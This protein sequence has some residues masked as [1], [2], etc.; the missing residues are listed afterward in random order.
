MLYFKHDS[1][2]PFY[3]SPFGAAP[4]GT[5]VTFRV[6][7]VD[8][9]N[10]QL[11]TYFRGVDHYYPMVQSP[12]DTQVYE[13]TLKLPG[14]TGL[15]WYDFHFDAFNAH[16]VYGTQ[17]D[18]IGGEGQV[19]LF[20]SNSYQ[21]TIYD[22]KRKVPDWYKEGLMYQIFPD[23]FAHGT[24]EGF[25]PH[26]PPHT[27]LHTNWTDSPH[28]FR[29]RADGSID[30]WDF[31]GGNLPGIVDKLDYLKDMGVS[32]LYLNPI[33]EAMSN[34][35]YDTADYMKIAGEFG[36]TEIF[37]TLCREAGKRGIRVILDGVFNHTGDDSRYFNRYG[38]FDDVGAYQSTESPYYHWYNFRHYPDDYDS[39]WGVRSMPSMNKDDHDYQHFIYAGDD[40]VVRTWLRRGASGWRLDVADELTDDFIVGIKDAMMTENPDTVLI[41]EVWEDASNKVAYGKYRDY[42][43]GRELDSVMNYPFRTAM[44]DF[45]NENISSAQAA[46]EMMS[47][48]E[49]YPRENFMSNMNLIGSH[50]RMRALTALS[51]VPENLSELERERYRLD[52]HKRAL[53][54]RKLS[55]LAL[56]QMTFPGVPCVYYG[57]EAGMEGF[58]D[59]YNRAAYPWG[60]EDED[61]QRW[62]KKIMRLRANN[63]VLK[64]GDWHPVA[65]PEDVFAFTRT[66]GGAGLFVAVNRSPYKS[67]TLSF[68]EALGGRDALTR[69]FVRTPDI[70]LAPLG[71]SVIEYR[72]KS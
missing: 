62:Y 71:C 24:R 49:H 31:F 32:I 19:N 46:R 27:L 53:A 7:S 45:F 25:S 44:L 9:M 66:H 28:Y 47:L 20:S 35:K 64:K 33:F 15:M 37:Q 38:H 57:D 12:D 72:L 61:L 30:Y 10:I 52:P 67:Y 41:G 11:H 2:D 51:D 18:G 58:E 23:R 59:P 3:K 5:E 4:A 8:T 13:Y 29:N 36:T 63:P 55:L 34:H 50:D 14:A 54:I 65:A 42:F 26:Y 48:Y 1:W 22:P 43:M 16:Y 21:L 56:V 6:R 39:W 69:E 70:F 60:Q 17:P 68:P 40:S